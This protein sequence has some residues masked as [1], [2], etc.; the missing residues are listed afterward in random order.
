MTDDDEH[1]R[2]KVLLGAARGSYLPPL[3]PLFA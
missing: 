2:V 3:P 1:D